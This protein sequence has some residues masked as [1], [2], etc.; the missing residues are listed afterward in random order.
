MKNISRKLLKKQNRRSKHLI[1]FDAVPTDK[2]DLLLCAKFLQLQDIWRFFFRCPFQI[3]PQHFSGI[4]PPCFTVGMRFFSWKGV[5]GLRQT[6][7]PLLQLN[8]SIFDQSVQ[9]TLF[10][11]AWFLPKCSLANCS[12][13]LMFFL[14][15]SG[16]FLAHL[17]C[18]SNLC[19]FF[20]TIDTCTLTPAVARAT[21]RSRLLVG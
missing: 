13:A 7:L 8:N 20:L 6:R 2:G 1:L 3:P 4:P 14:D 16:F 11:K 15:S 12:L 9:S 5:L 17:P 19:C 10:Q 21:W 18:R